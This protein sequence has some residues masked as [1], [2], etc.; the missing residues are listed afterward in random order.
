MLPTGGFV[1]LDE[2][3][4]FQCPA[5]AAVAVVIRQLQ[6]IYGSQLKVTFFHFPLA[7][8]PHAREAALAAEAASLQ[9][10]FSEMHDLLYQNQ[11]IWSEAPNVQKLFDSYARSLGLDLSQFRAD[12]ESKEVAARIASDQ[13]RGQAL[14][15]KNTPTLFVNDREV[16][17]PFRLE[18]LRRE[19]DAALT[20]TPPRKLGVDSGL[21]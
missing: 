10:H 6:Q 4:D 20:Q 14:G 21:R 3:G 11:A 5:C 7:I 19:I 9:G 17:P 12:Y 16:P 15:V 1:R 13:K 18:R 2:Y 8:H